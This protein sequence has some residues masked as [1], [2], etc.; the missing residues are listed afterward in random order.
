LVFMIGFKTCLTSVW[1]VW[2]V[3]W[4]IKRWKKVAL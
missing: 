3:F 2:S 1:H 4:V